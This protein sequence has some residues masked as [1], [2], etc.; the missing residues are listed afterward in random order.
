MYVMT[1]SC[2]SIF[3]GDARSLTDGFWFYRCS[4]VYFA[5]WGLTTC[6]GELVV[7]SF[8]AVCVVPDWERLGGSATRW[9][10]RTR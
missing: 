4:T 3:V 10:K 2:L 9:R 7:F 1:S 6:S 8:A 5:S